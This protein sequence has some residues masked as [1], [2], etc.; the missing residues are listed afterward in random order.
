VK[1]RPAAPWPVVP[2]SAR[3][4]ALDTYLQALGPQTILTGLEAARTQ[5]QQQVLSDSR[6]QIY[7]GGR[8]DVA[9]GRV[10]VRVLAM[11]EY[12]AQANGEVSVSCLITGHSL[13]VH[14]RPGVV[15]AHIYGRAVDIS[16]VGN[17]PIVGHQGPGS[18]TERTIRQILAL[19]ASVEPLQVISLMTL[20]GPSFA[21][22]DHYDHIHV[23]Y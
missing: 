10:D 13:Y 17:V 12:L 3:A 4:V 2:P 20:G 15:S 14:G 8:G 21:L 19:P 6:V 9:S 18:V 16:A 11:I 23:G 7:P 22:P 1:V 5:L